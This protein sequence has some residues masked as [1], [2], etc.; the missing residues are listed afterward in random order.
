VDVKSPTEVSAVC[1]GLSSVLR[2]GRRSVEFSLPV[3]DP[4]F[5]FQFELRPFVQGWRDSFFESL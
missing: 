1:N 5:R 3:V 4:V 2:S